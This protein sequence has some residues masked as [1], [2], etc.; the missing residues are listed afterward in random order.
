MA[1][2]QGLAHSIDIADTL[3]TVVG[4]AIS[5]LDDSINNIFDAFGIDEMGHAKLFG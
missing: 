2:F 5:E 1:A 4:S 3:K